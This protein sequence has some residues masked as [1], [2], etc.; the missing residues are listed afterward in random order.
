LDGL[1][2]YI[3]NPI[4]AKTFPVLEKG[5]EEEKLKKRFLMK[6]LEWVLFSKA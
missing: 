5:K 3:P 1:L 2:N 6:D 4:E